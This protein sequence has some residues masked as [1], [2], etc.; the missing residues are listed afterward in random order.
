M[1]AGL[2]AGAGTAARGSRPARLPGVGQGLELERPLDDDLVARLE[3]AEDR[4]PGRPRAC[5]TVDVAALEPL[6]A[7]LD[8][9]ERPLALGQEGRGGDDARRCGPTG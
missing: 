2:R 9:D 7:G 4:R 3:A 8:E 5:P 1:R 6:G